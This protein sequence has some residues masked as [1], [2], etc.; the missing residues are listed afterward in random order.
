VRHR[1]QVRH[2]A[3][4]VIDFL[5]AVVDRHVVRFAVPGGTAILRRDDDVPA[6]DRFLDEG[7]VRDRPVPMHPAVHPDHRGVAARAPFLQRLKQIRRNV[8][9]TDAGAVLH[10]RA[11]EDPFARLHVARVIVGFGLDGLLEVRPGMVLELVGD[12]QLP[13]PR[14][15]ERLRAAPAALPSAASGWGRR[16][17]LL[18]LRAGLLRGA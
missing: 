11:L 2:R 1:L 8:D 18:L 4:H 7:E 10:L 6:R 16:L 13:R 12:I 5:A 17:L 3:H 14:L 15:I 9:V